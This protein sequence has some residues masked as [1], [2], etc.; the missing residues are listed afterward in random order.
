MHELVFFK[1][2]TRIRYRDVVVPAITD[3]ELPNVLTRLGL[4]LRKN[5]DTQQYRSNNNG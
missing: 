3:D 1:M 5:L 4:Y 2:R